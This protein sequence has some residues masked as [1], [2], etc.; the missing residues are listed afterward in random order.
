[1]EPHLRGETLVSGMTWLWGPRAD[2]V[3]VFQATH[4]SRL[5]LSLPENLHTSRHVCLL[6]SS[7]IELLKQETHD[8]FFF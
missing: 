1:M 4:R 2:E 7:N 5:E 8:R 3:C 6:S